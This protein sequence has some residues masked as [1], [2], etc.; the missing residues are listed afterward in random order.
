MKRLLT[1]A[2]L[3][4]DADCRDALWKLGG[5]YEVAADVEALFADLADATDDDVVDAVLIDVAAPIRRTRL[6]RR[7]SSA[8]SKWSPEDSFAFEAFATVMSVSEQCAPGT[9]NYRDYDPECDLWVPAETVPMEIRYAL[10][11]NI[12]LG[13]H[14]GAV[15]FKRWDGR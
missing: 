9:L 5:K 2:A 15:I 1:A 12:G 14:N 6:S 4:V 10:S 13:G 8:R 11:N 3:A 7:S